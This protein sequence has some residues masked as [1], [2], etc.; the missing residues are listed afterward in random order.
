MTVHTRRI[1]MAA[2]TIAV[3]MTLVGPVGSGGPTG[4]TTISTGITSVRPVTWVDAQGRQVTVTGTTNLNGNIKKLVAFRDLANGQ[5]DAAFGT[6]E[7]RAGARELAFTAPAAG[8]VREH[9]AAA[10]DDGE[11]TITWIP[12]A[13]APTT[14]TC[15]RWF[16]RFDVDGN[17]LATPVK[18]SS[19]DQPV[20]GLR[21]GS[22]LTRDPSGIT[23]W[24]GPDGTDRGL[25]VASGQYR[26]AAI[27]ASGRLLVSTAAGHV[28]RKPADA[29]QDL[30]L[31]LSGACS[32]D[33]AGLAVAAGDVAG[34]ATVC[35]PTPAGMVV[36]RR[37]DD[38]DV[39]WSTTGPGD[40]PSGRLQRVGVGTIDDLDRVWLGGYG[41]H[42]PTDPTKTVVL[43]QPVT[44]DG[45]GEVAYV[46]DSPHFRTYEFLSFGMSDLRPAPAHEVAMAEDF[47]CCLQSGGAQFQFSAV[48][49]RV[50][51]E[52]EAAPACVPPTLFVQTAYAKRILVTARPCPTQ[53]ATS[54][55]DAYEVRAVAPSGTVLSSVVVSA[56][57]LPDPTNVDLAP[58]ANGQVALVSIRA[59]NAAGPGPAT[60]AIAVIP[61]FRDLGEFVSDMFSVSGVT[62]RTGEIDDWHSS[63]TS[64]TQA[65]ADLVAHLA[66]VG[67][68]HQHEEP[69]AR[70]YRA[71]F[72]RNPDVGGFRYW[73]DRRL[74]GRTL[75]RISDT[76]AASSEFEARYGSLSNRRFVA[77]LYQNV[78][79]RPADPSGLAYW[80]KRLDD[81]RSTRGQVVLQF[82]ESREGIRRMQ[83]LVEPLAVAFTLLGRMPTAAERD[84]WDD[85][86]RFHHDVAA[87]ILASDEFAQ[88]WQ[89]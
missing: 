24:V 79:G 69:L 73:I 41:D 25:S 71:Y 29:P 26:S 17:S 31:D 2:T 78:F 20:W 30:D 83:P 50:L 47:G 54:A 74:E 89:T 80:T 16:T 67:I 48:T 1:A 14:D 61:P 87:V 51:P 33:G 57:N 10:T 65:P 46:R 13:C 8:V 82:S 88:R 15:D 32:A 23:G 55:P 75:T 81:Q 6:F 72:L 64:G 68:A 59:V 45:V 35:S 22:F 9:I 44:D 76:F 4:A 77:K 56:P 63:L 3:V 34:F 58:I 36:D 40:D 62:P 49:A 38:G 12:P 11:I 52:A 7:G 27:D 21:D 18:T 42:V 60:S 86:G 28:V 19:D 70:L 5:P 39:R 43:V 85:V 84:A 53:P 37:E 66:E